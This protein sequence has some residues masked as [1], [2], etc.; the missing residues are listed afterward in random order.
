MKKLSLTTRVLVALV[1]GAI[2]GLVLYPFQEIPFV[3]NVIIDFGFVLVGQVF[4]SLIK[5]MV[6][7]LVFVSLVVGAAMIG[8]VRKLGRIGLKTLLFYLI[9]TAIAITIAIGLANITNPGLAADIGLESADYV[10]KE[11]PSFV[12]VLINIVPT[13]PISSM[14]EG[15]MLQIIV[16]ALFLGTAITILKDKTKTV[17]NFFEELNHINLKIVEMIMHVA[18]I[19]VFC[20]IARTFATLGWEMFEPLA[21]YMITVILA[22]LIHCFVTYQG[23]LLGFTR[24]SPRKFFSNIFPAVTVAFSTASSSSTLP[25]TIDA[26]VKRNGVDE[27]VASFCLPLGATIN[28]DGT[29]IMQGV[30]TVFIAQLYGVN[31]T[32]DQYVVVII[33]ATLASI[34]TAG[35]PGVGLIMLS[36]VLQ[37]VGLPV[38]GIAIIMGV[39]RILDMI[40]TAVNITGDAV[41]TCIIADS[42][43]ALNR[44]IFNESK[45][46][47]FDKEVVE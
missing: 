24:L 43:N 42:E 16:F 29:A 8:D 28:M 47:K 15:N 35:V 22:L 7:P 9:T 3:S 30:A 20:L 37:Q 34:G 27:E 21:V 31:L 38:E 46:A 45:D 12:N 5:M 36:M 10:A 26:S 44:E 14:A 18:P 1:L 32:I 2:F 4:L 33:T 25:V 40:R 17:Y 23:F 13:N 39:D 6:V 19:G 11:A 41:C